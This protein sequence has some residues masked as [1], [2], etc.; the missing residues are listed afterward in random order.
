MASEGRRSP[1]GAPAGGAG[2]GS[3]LKTLAESDALAAPCASEAARARLCAIER[4]QSAIKQSAM[5]KP[6]R[7]RLA[8][9]PWVIGP[10]WDTFAVEEEVS[11]MVRE[12]SKRAG[13]AGA[14]E[15]TGTALSSG[16]QLLILEIAGRKKPLDWDYVGRCTRY[17][18]TVKTALN[19]GGRFKAYRAYIVAHRIDSSPALQDYLRDL[20]GRGTVARRWPDLLD[21]SK[22]AWGEYLRVLAGRGNGATGDARPGAA[23][24][25]PSRS[26]SAERTQRRRAASPQGYRARVR[27]ASRN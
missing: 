26:A 12:Q 27:S 1:Q 14:R 11:A 5:E 22:A 13:M 24:S 10:S 6:V 20:Q 18:Q 21:E 17:V 9:S 8:A 2:K 3:L 23:A 15:R 7:D 4:L 16:S 19:K 25:R